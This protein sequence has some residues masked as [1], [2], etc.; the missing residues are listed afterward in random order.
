[1]P[2]NLP[3]GLVTRTGVDGVTAVVPEAVQANF[4]TLASVDNTVSLVVP[5]LLNGFVNYGGGFTPPRYYAHAS[6]R[7]FIEGLVSNPGAPA[8]NTPIF[9]LPVGLRPVGGVL[10]FDTITNTGN[11]G[12]VDV[13][14]AGQVMYMAGGVGWLN[15]SG[16]SL[17]RG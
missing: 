2:T 14:G 16:I 17:Q 12:R 4:E 15:L 6:G 10:I 8:V 1:M 7:V 11:N 13:D 9:T 5:T 3:F